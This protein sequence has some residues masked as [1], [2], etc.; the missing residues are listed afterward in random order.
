MCGIANKDSEQIFLQSPIFERVRIDLSGSP[1]DIPGL[2][3]ARIDAQ[4]LRDLILFVNP[5]LTL[6]ANRMIMEATINSI[7]ATK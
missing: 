6:V 5:D 7:K 4:S 1:S 2:D 3:I